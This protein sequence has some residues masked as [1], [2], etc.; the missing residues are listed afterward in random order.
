MTKEL[1][2]RKSTRLQGFDYSSVGAYFVTVCTRERNN[3]FWKFVGATIGR[4]QE[5]EFPL[6]EYGK[7]VE[8]SILRIPKIYPCV[9]IE[10]Y[11]I[12]PDHIHVLLTISADE[13][14]R[15]MV[16]PTVSRIVQQLKGY[17]TKQIG[18][19][20]WQKSFFDHIIRNRK[21]YEEHIKYI[22]EN[23][24]RLTINGRAML[25]PTKENPFPQK[26]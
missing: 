22:Y 17:V 12:M 10:Y 13:Y 11:I 9:K 20:I 18:S 24:L 16:A 5:Q 26:T 7:I 3:Y 15:P 19:S 2:Q 21:D 25:A 1:P 8:N 6:S 4:P 14:G 23:P